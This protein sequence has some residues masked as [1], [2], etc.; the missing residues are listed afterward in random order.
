MTLLRAPLVHSNFNLNSTNCTIV[1]IKTWLRYYGGVK[2]CNRLPVHRQKTTLTRLYI[3]LFSIQSPTPWLS[4]RLSHW[5]GH[6]LGQLSPYC[7]HLSYVYIEALELHLQ[8]SRLCNSSH[9]KAYSYEPGSHYLLTNH[10]D[11]TTCCTIYQSNQAP[12]SF[13]KSLLL[14][15]LQVS[16]ASSFIKRTDD[17]PRL[18]TVPDRRTNWRIKSRVRNVK[19]RFSPSHQLDPAWPV[20]ILKMT[21]WKGL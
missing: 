20:K 11:R 21:T 18:T 14:L 13:K 17:R 6:W 12:T 19:I 2:K 16:R 8:S 15:S 9:C 5:L 7:L 4:H 3:T 10:L 1:G